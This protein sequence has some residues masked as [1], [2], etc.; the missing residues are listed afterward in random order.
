M[1]KN[2]CKIPQQNARKRNIILLKGLYT[3]PSGIY[4]WKLEQFG[5]PW[6]LPGAE[7]KNPPPMQEM[8]VRFLGWECPL[9]KEI[10]TYSSILVW[11]I[12]GTEEPGQLQSTGSQVS[13]VT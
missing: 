4:S 11:E 13:H 2:K 9:E 8:W 3:R 5:L 6:W 1:Q 7:V 10:A 12:L